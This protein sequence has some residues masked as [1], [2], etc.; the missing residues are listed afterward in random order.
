MGILLFIMSL[1][2]SFFLGLKNKNFDDTFMSTFYGLM[3]T[4]SI[5]SIQIIWT[6]LILISSSKE[7]HK[8]KVDKIRSSAVKN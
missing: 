3:V 5:K 1:L 8:F 6:V 4:V 2:V 7:N